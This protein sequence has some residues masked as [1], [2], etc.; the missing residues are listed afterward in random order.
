MRR[1]CGE[2]LIGHPRQLQQCEH[3]LAAIAVRHYP[4]RVMDL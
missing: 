4:K 2:L 3:D 1:V